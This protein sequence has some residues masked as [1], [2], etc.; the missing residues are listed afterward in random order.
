MATMLANHEPISHNLNLTADS[1]STEL[2]E[3]RPPA[4]ATSRKS[5][6]GVPGDRA[7]AEA[8]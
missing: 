1:R 3:R 5:A 6:F 4:P 2:M 7:A 8:S